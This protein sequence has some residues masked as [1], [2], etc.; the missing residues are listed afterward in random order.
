MHPIDIGV[1][2][3]EVKSDAGC[4]NYSGQN[5]AYGSNG[6]A[7]F[8]QLFVE[9]CFYLVVNLGSFVYFAVFGMITHRMYPY[10]AVSINH[11]T[12]SKHMVGRISRFVVEF[13]GNDA[14]T[15]YRFA[16]Q[17]GFVHLKCD[18][19]KKLAVCRNFFSRFE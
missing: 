8:V 2:I 16:G 5:I 1:I 6:I 9:R 4:K 10:H 11:R 7:K 14:F 12:A 3:D 19:F 15:H 13:T 17:V 18:G